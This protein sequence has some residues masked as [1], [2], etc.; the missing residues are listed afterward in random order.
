MNKHKSKWAPKYLKMTPSRRKQFFWWGNPK[1]N[2]KNTCKKI[3]MRQLNGFQEIEEHKKVT[4]CKTSKKYPKTAH[5]RRLT[6]MKTTLCI[7]NTFTLSFKGPWKVSKQNIV[8]LWE[9]VGHTHRKT[10]WQFDLITQLKVK[11]HRFYP[12]G[13][14]GGG[15]VRYPSQQMQF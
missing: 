4:I 1:S 5:H 3:Y 15:L 11:I 14:G 13:G 8:L 2:T 9:T 7:W 12:R 10:N 6:Y